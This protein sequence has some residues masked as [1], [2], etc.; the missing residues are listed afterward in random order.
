[1][2]NI[3]F[4]ILTILKGTIH[5][6]HHHFHFQNFSPPRTETVLKPSSNKESTSSR[7]RYTMLIIQQSKN[8]ALSIKRQDAQS[9]T[10]PTDTPKLTTEHFI[11]P[12]AAMGMNLEA[13]PPVSS[14][15]Q[16]NRP[17]QPRSRG[18]GAT[19]ASKCFLFT[20]RILAEEEYC[21]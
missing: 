16:Q 13:V 12:G 17:A 7:A 20:W 19:P 3:K 1:M 21:C 6:D 11:A 10:K 9:Y 18:L 5:N 2:H 8:I 4:T 14:R 15:G